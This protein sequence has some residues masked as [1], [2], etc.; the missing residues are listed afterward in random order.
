MTTLAR[1]DGKRTFGGGVTPNLLLQQRRGSSNRREWVPQFMPQGC[2]ELILATVGFAQCL[3]GSL[4]LGD[5]VEAI[6]CAC[7]FSLLVVL[8]SDIHD[9]G[10]PRAIGPLDENLGVTDS[11]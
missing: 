4:A 6:D 1:D 2:H 3:L 10:D 8:R 9:H 5:V 7:H 11:R